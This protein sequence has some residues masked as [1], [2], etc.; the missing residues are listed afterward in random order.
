MKIA[1]VS[2]ISVRIV[3]MKD[4]EMNTYNHLM[5][6]VKNIKKI[7]KIIWWK[8]KMIITKTKLDMIELK[9]PKQAILENKDQIQIT[10]WVIIS[11]KKKKIKKIAK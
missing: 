1:F 8:F 7:K 9:K 4:T 11:R 10:L 6:K 2:Q 5:N 3:K